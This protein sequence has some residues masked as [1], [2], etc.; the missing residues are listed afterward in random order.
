MPV[1]GNGKERIEN[2]AQNWTS[3]KKTGKNEI[4][5]KMNEIATKKKL[6]GS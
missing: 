1:N 3:R 5:T 2:F 4:A 6:G